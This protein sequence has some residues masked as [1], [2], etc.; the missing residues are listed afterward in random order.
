MNRKN[1]RVSAASRENRFHRLYFIWPRNTNMERLA[2]RIV[3]IRN[4]E[5]MC[6][7]SHKK[8]YKAKVKFFIGEE[9]R[10]V[11]GFLSRRVDSKF[12]TITRSL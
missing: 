4:V 8:G 5:D 7:E 11:V 1:K 9:P 12:G 6:I 10:D 3:G 2:E